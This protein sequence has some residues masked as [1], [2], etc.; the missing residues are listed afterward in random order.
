M[1]CL[2]TAVGL[3]YPLLVMLFIS[4]LKRNTC[5]QKNVNEQLNDT[6]HDTRSTRCV[7]NLAVAHTQREEAA[8]FTRL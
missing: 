2:C 6:T 5:K 1:A 8:T 4:T 3:V 7:G